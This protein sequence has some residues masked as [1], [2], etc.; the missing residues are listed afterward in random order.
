VATI[1]ERKELEALQNIS[2]NVKTSGA[3]FPVDYDSITITY[4][5][6]TNL[7][8]TAVFKLG[9]TAVK[10][11]TLNYDGSNRLLAAVWS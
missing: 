4:V 3:S 7:V 2:L 8:S 1:I 5:P 6:D 10:T 9:V 11:L